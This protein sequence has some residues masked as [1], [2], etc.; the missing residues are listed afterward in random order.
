MLNAWYMLQEARFDAAWRTHLRRAAQQMGTF[1]AQLLADRALVA[2]L[3]RVLSTVISERPR[4]LVCAHSNCGVNDPLERLMRE[5]MRNGDGN[6]CRPIV[7]RAGRGH[8]DELP[9][10]VQEARAALLGLTAAR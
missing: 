10:N 6:P 9:A 8:D 2:N 5:P 7:V 4:M 1:G 3:Q